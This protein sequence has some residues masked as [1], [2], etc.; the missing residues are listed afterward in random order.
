MMPH[1]PSLDPGCLDGG[2]WAGTRRAGWAVAAGVVALLATAA[3]PAAAEPPVAPGPESVAVDPEIM[4]A[5]L[6]QEA[7]PPVRGPRPGAVPLG[8]SEQP[9]STAAS[10]VPRPLPDWRL[11]AALGAAFAAVA[12]YRFVAGRGSQ[13]LPPDVF[14]LL[15]EASLGGQQSVRV[16]RFG[17]RTLLVGVS[18]A[19]CQTLA[20]ITDSQSTE[21][22][23]SACRGTRLRGAVGGLVGG[24]SATPAR[25]RSQAAEKPA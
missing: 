11:L 2:L 18:S 23:V 24:S 20:E 10:A 16:V 22:I 9:A 12:A 8:A 6:V 25:G 15:G 19:G 5:S 7:S 1:A 3:H 21:C 14:E 13:T 4:P 17:P